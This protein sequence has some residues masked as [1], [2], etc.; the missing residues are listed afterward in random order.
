[1]SA[2][3]KPQ[4]LGIRLGNPIIC[5]R[6]LLISNAFEDL[7][8]EKLP[9]SHK[10]IR[11]NYDKVGDCVH[12]YYNIFNNKFVADF[13]YVIMK[14]LEWIFLLTLYTFDKNPENRIAKQY[15]SYQDR[16]SIDNYIKE[17]S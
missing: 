10:I 17:E 4:R 5:N 15:V 3:V 13:V 14:P 9:V 11:K 2:I 8:Q 6:Q 16:K 1:H 7:L 12:R